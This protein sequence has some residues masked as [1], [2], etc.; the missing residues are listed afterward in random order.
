M[1]QWPTSFQIG[2]M[3]NAAARGCRAYDID[4]TCSRLDALCFDRDGHHSFVG[5]PV[6]G[7]DEALDTCFEEAQRRKSGGREFNVQI[8]FLPPRQ[9]LALAGE[10]EHSASFFFECSARL[11]F[12]ESSWNDTFRD[13]FK[14]LSRMIQG[15]VIKTNCQLSLRKSEPVLPSFRFI[16]QV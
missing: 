7:S 13:H 4:A 15:F 16:Q 12:A 5:R 1:A 2:G 3:R 8:S 11:S 6:V 9:R 10:I 14:I